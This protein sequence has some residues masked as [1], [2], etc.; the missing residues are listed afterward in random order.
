MNDENS[1][2]LKVNLNQNE[3]N[4]LIKDYKKIKKYMK[5]SLYQIK[6]MDLKRDETSSN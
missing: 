1:N 4:K 3:L 5:S 6:K 2:K